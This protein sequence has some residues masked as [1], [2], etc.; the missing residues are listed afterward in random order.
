M[1]TFA[2]QSLGSGMEGDKFNGVLFQKAH[3]KS[4]A[5]GTDKLSLFVVYLCESTEQTKKKVRERPHFS[6]LSM[7]VPAHLHYLDTLHLTK[8][9][10][11]AWRRR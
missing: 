9:Q 4:G 8:A 7:F 1:T 11:C 2:V 10:V 3:F 5:F 6:Y